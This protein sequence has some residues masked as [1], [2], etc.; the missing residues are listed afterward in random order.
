MGTGR[1]QLFA[2]GATG[3]NPSPK[4][5]WFSPSSTGPSK[6]EHC[7]WTLLLKKED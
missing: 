4:A 3:I 5:L 2:A 1:Q 7:N 6:G